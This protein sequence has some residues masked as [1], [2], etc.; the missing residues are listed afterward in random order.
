M[1]FCSQETTDGLWLELIDHQRKLTIDSFRG[2]DL[3]D[4]AAAAKSLRSRTNI[5][6]RA[7]A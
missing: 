7:R 6:R 1:K 2:R 3:E 5:L 4:I